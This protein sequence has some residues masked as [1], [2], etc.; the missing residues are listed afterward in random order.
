MNC[1]ETE[2]LLHGLLDDEV[3]PENANGIETHL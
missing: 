2:I 3:D 1:D